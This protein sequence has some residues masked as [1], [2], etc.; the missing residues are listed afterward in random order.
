[1]L[2]VQGL[3]PAG[4]VYGNSGPLPLFAIGVVPFFLLIVVGIVVDSG[5]PKKWAMGVSAEGH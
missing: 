3:P 4:A 1:M 2:F 5:G